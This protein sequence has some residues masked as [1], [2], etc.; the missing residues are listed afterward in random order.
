MPSVNSTRYGRRR[1]TRKLADA[2]FEVAR[3]DHTWL[4]QPI[5]MVCAQRKRRMHALHGRAQL[6]HGALQVV[7]GR[8]MWITRRSRVPRRRAERQH[9]RSPA[10]ASSRCQYAASRTACMA[11]RDAFDVSVR[12]I[13]VS[14]SFGIVEGISCTFGDF[15]NMVADRRATAARLP[16]TVG[17][18]PCIATRQAR[19]AA[20]FRLS[21]GVGPS[22]VSARPDSASRAAFIASR[23]PRI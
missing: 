5:D 7:H 1:R 16:F 17:D 15:S 23:R 12:A 11:R 18:R 6:L 9:G 2:Q 10:R 22:I 8:C 4:R 20:V 13:T 3:Q 14:R 21:V 19:G